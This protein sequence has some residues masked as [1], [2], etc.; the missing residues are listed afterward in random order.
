MG[1]FLS[2]THFVME[3]FSCVNSL[4]ITLIWDTL[5]MRKSVI[6]YCS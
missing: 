4:D 1:H 3:I 2:C 6:V 5:R